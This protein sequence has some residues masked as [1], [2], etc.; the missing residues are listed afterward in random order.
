M[1]PDYGSGGSHFTEALFIGLNNEIPNL[2][3]H[4]SDFEINPERDKIVGQ[5]CHEN[6]S[7]VLN[8]IN[9][10]KAD[11]TTLKEEVLL[12]NFI[13]KIKSASEIYIYYDR[14]AGDEVYSLNMD[15]NVA[16]LVAGWYNNGDTSHILNTT[17]VTL[18]NLDE[19]IAQDSSWGLK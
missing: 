4:D 8:M 2:I 17:F 16:I 15:R 9:A 11:F 10:F 18:D 19:I 5:E 6:P 12:N 13:Q 7:Y 3:K 1:I 14:N